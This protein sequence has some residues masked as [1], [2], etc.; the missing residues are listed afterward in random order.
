MN[1][2]ILWETFSAEQCISNIVTHV[3]D[4]FLGDGTFYTLFYGILAV[5]AIVIATVQIC[6]N[7]TKEGWLIVVAIV[8]L[9]V[10]SFLLTILMGDISPIRAQLG[11]PMILACNV[12]IL[13]RFFTEM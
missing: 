3:K 9:Q 13:G 5:L 11:Y 2:K 8:A 12:L 7:R 6:K 1:S 4:G 10:S